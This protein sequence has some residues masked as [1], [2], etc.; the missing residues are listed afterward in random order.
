MAALQPVMFPDVEGPD[1]V[2]STEVADVADTVLNKHGKVGGVG[3]L[4]ATARAIADEE[5]HVLWLL[6]TKPFDPEKDAEGHDVAGKC[7]K[8]PGLWHDVTGFD[9]AIWIREYFWKRWDQPTR[10][11]ALLHELLHVEVDR[12]QDNNP[13]V[14]IRKHEVEDFVDVVRHYGPIFGEGARLVRAAATFAGEPAPIH[15]A[16]AAAHQVVDAVAPDATRED[17][18]RQVDEAADEIDRGRRTAPPGIH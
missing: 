16:R 15:S 13:K 9:V 10:E 12:D 5:V 3:L 17:L 7:V 8:A 11:A 18:H 6:N 1:F 14:K 4:H 2:R